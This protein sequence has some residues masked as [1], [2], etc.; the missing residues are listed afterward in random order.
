MS[1]V[2]FSQLDI[3]APDVNLDVGSGSHARQTAEIMSRMEPVLLERK[4]NIVLVY[5]DVNSTVVAALVCSK[6]LIRI[7]HVE[8]GVAFVRSNHA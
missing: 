5:G 1:D 8:A 4:P 6:L 2:F 3:P 7:A